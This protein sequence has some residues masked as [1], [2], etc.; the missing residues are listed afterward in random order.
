MTKF[1]IQIWLVHRM[2][3]SWQKGGVGLKIENDFGG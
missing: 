3:P 1:D 2:H